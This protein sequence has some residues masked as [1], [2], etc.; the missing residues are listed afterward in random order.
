MLSILIDI[1]LIKVIDNLK[2]SYNEQKSKYETDIDHLKKE[3]NQSKIDLQGFE[4]L[5]YFLKF[6]LK[7]FFS[8]ST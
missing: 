4:R 5:F 1:N 6:F 3:Y 8:D 2:N 7:P